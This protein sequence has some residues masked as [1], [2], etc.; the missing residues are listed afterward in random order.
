ME[1]TKSLLCVAILMAAAEVSAAED[2]APLPTWPWPGPTPPEQR[3]AML[4]RTF[5][6][7]LTPQDLK[8][9]EKLAPDKP[10]AAPLKPRKLLCWGR[11][12]TH[13]A[14]SFAEETVKILGRK[15]GAFEVVATDD[16]QLLLP[17]KLKEFDA[18]FFNSLHDRT[19]SCR[20]G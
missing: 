3:E 10:Q 11:H 14:N 1:T 7:K 17:E 5:V 6:F 2:K 19:P 4:K 12:W 20:P 15:T 13:M 9:M 8:E 16:P 18:I